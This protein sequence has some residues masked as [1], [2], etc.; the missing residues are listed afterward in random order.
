M[1]NDIVSGECFYG[2]SELNGQSELTDWVECFY[3]Q[4]DWVECFYGQIDWVEC[5]YG[6]S[7]LTDW[8]D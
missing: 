2:Q 4:I 3:G 7:E 6:Q 1:Y 5:F 8:V